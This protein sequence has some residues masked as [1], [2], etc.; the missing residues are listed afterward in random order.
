MCVEFA[1]CRS[2]FVCLT[3][4]TDLVGAF[5]CS[6]QARPSEDCTFSDNGLANSSGQRMQIAEVRSRSTF[7]LECLRVTE[8]LYPGSCS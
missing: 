2:V 5:A 3:L 1:G 4:L 6:A 8:R 7:Q